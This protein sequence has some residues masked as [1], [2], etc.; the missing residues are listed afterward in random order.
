MRD[1]E[2]ESSEPHSEKLIPAVAEK[3]SSRKPPALKVKYIGSLTMEEK[4]D[5]TLKLVIVLIA[6]NAVLI[7]QGLF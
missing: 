1:V 7:L 5:L 6:L 2:Y 3:N 4:V